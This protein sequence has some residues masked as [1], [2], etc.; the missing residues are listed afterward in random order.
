VA[1]LTPASY[2]PDQVFD[3]WDKAQHASAFLVLT[4]LGF[5]AFPASAM[6]VA[7]GLLVYGGMIELAQ[8]AT[9]WRTGDWQD[10]VADAIGVLAACLA[11]FIRFH[12][13][14]RPSGNAPELRPHTA[15]ATLERAA[16]SRANAL[17]ELDKI[18]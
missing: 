3:I 1:A 2:L 4:G 12:L 17:S 18:Q 11:W 9:G 7:V 5:W 8:A 6:R 15:D 13:H 10:W 14:L 16:E